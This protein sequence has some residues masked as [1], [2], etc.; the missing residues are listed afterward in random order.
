MIWVAQGAYITECSDDKTIGKNNGIFWGVFWTS[1]ALGSLITGLTYTS[2]FYFFIIMSGISL[3]GTILF[4]FLPHSPKEK[5][6]IGKNNQHIT[7]S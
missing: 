1:A 4:C 5:I 6:L 7:P 3:I 2:P